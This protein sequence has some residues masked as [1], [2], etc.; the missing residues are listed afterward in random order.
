MTRRKQPLAS[1]KKMKPCK[2]M[3]KGEEC[4]E[5]CLRKNNCPYKQMLCKQFKSVITKEKRGKGICLILNKD[6]VKCQG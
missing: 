3:N 2:S 4:L 1:A 6:Y 5:L